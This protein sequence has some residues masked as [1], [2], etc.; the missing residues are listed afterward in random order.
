MTREEC[1]KT[2]EESLKNSGQS[3]F[4]AAAENFVIISSKVQENVAET[5]RN[6]VEFAINITETAASTDKLAGNIDESFIN[7]SETAGNAAQSEIN[8][9]GYAKNIAYTEGNAGSIIKDRQNNRENTE[10]IIVRHGESIGNAMRVMLGHTDLDLSELGYRQAECTARHLLGKKIDAIYSSDLKR[11]YNTAMEYAKLSDISVTVD[12][13]LREIKVGAW[14]G[15]CVDEVIERWGDEYTVGWC[16]GFG[17]FK[18][19]EGEDVMVGGVRFYNTVLEIARRHPGQTVLIAT[20]AGVLRAFWA[21]ISC[22]DREKIVGVLPFATNASCSY[23]VFDGEKMIPGKYSEDE[24]LSEVGITK[25]R[26]G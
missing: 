25:V 1:E 18:F 3:N 11:A 4:C 6:A 20:H 15:I 22:I 2:R 9:A 12:K 17:T 16:Q 8:T 13:G 24:H 19:P 26:T 7:T 23:V 5:A 21:I 14:E 10:I